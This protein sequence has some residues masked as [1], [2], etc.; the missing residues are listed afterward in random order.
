EDRAC[1]RVVAVLYRNN[2][3]RIAAYVVRFPSSLSR[4]EKQLVALNVHPNHCELRLA[5]SIERY[6]MAIG[7][8]L[9]Y[10]SQGFR[11]LYRH[12]STPFV[13]RLSVIVRYDTGPINLI[14]FQFRY[15]FFLM[16][17]LFLTVTYSLFARHNYQ[18]FG[19]V[20]L[21]NV[22]VRWLIVLI[23][24]GYLCKNAS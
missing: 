3:A 18:L 14:S 13:L 1:L 24:G 15:Y 5:L 9:E 16:P 10:C 8:I 6:D 7:L 22:S 11:K 23:L 21:W 4:V 12:R 2:H 19:R 20:P 17:V